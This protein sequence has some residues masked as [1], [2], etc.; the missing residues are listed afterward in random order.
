ML[1]WKSIIKIQSPSPLPVYLQIAN[2]II[3]EIKSGVVKPNVKMP[4]TRILAELIQVHRQTV[5]NAYSELDAQGWIV[6]LP[7][8]GSFVNE[9]LPETSYGKNH[10]HKLMNIEETGYPLIANP[11]I[12]IPSKSHREVTGFHDGPDVRLVPVEQLS[13]AY[14]NVLG[15]RPLIHQ[16]SYVDVE[17]KSLLR[18]VLSEELNTSRGMQTTA[19]N[20]FITRGSQMALYMIARVALAKNDVVLVGDTN[21]YYADRVFMN[22]GAKLLRVT[23]DE[24]GIDVEQIEKLCKRKKIRAVY[25]TSHHHY[26][27]TVT[28]SAAR[29]MKLLALSEQYGFIIIEDDYDYDFHYQSNPIL[30]LASAD[31]KGMVVY[32]GTLS[33]SVAPAMRIGY[34]AAPK[35]F[36]TELSK[37]RQIIDIQGDPILEQAVAELFV[38]GEIRRHMKKS[39]KEY[40]LRRDFMCELLNQKLSD[41]IE[42]KIPEGGLAVWAR[43]DK[44][45]KLPEVS[46]KLRKKGF[47]LS[48]GLIHDTEEKKLNST[49]MGFGW[50]NTAEADKA[51]NALYGVI[52]NC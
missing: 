27:T 52:K 39:L 49:R 22:V 3:K 9:H 29:R 47:V 21:Y 26:P 32:I 20:I 7:S 37:L 4:G 19:D 50:M 24:Q 31:K 14:K 11:T 45:I 48:N 16:L 23:I 30:P 41:C 25:V 42:F 44:K 6:S 2:C 34:V 51:V 17:G 35:N 10:L 18:K 36:I 15:R 33:K 12:H 46:A 28:L 1:P 40:R 8:K 43:Y 5:V 13:R 38:Q